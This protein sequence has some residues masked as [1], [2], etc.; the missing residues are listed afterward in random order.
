MLS[1]PAS[2]PSYAILE[3]LAPPR[4]TSRQA[5]FVAATQSAFLKL[6]G[7]K[8]LA[9]DFVGDP[10]DDGLTV[11]ETLACDTQEA[12][13]STAILASWANALAHGGTA[14][15]INAILA[16]LPDP[17]TLYLP[18]SRWRSETNLGPGTLKI[19]DTLYRRIPAA[20]S[21]LT[22]FARDARQ[23]GKDRAVTLHALNLIDT[24]RELAG[25]ARDAVSALQPAGR[26][27]LD[28]RY[29]RT[30]DILY[31][32]LTSC[33]NGQHP[34]IDDA[35]A[36]LRP[37]LPQRRRASR[38][39]L[40]APLRLTY[41]DAE[42]EHRALEAY[43]RDISVGGIGL[44]SVA[45]IPPETLLSVHLPDGRRMKAWLAW[46]RDGEAGLSF[47]QPLFPGDPLVAPGPI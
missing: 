8:L 43:G 10:V 33:M 47:V 1:E 17:P 13:M 25:L 29:T 34:C 37:E 9:R 11:L 5:E 12:A 45:R 2:A 27:E 36:I 41:R 14:A 38:K 6:T 16:A 32:L 15:D 21:M 46:W 23:I 31:A 3:A 20:R 26:T 28:E 30:S 42:G 24:A 22:A 4:S 40:D 39:R 44:T 7:R 19:V 35:G 18:M